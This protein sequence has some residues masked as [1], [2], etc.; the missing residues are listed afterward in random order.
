MGLLQLTNSLTTEI[1]AGVQWNPLPQA[2][3]YEATIPIVYRTKTL[4]RPEDKLTARGSPEFCEKEDSTFCKVLN[5]IDETD[6][7]L[8]NFL[9]H[10]EDNIAQEFRQQPASPRKRSLDFVGEF[11]EWCCGVATQRRL[12]SVALGEAYLQKRLQVLQTGLM[13]SLKNLGDESETFQGYSNNITDCF[14]QVSSRLQRITKAINIEK[15]Q[16]SKK[17]DNLM[18]NLAAGITHTLANMKKTFRLANIIQQLDTLNSCRLHHIPIHVVKP[19]VLKADLQK[20]QE[21]LATHNHRLTIDPS[22]VT[23]YYELPICDCTFTADEITLRIKVPIVRRDRQWKLLETVTT[24]FAWKNATCKLMH[25]VTYLAVD[26]NREI[27]PISG[28]HLH[29][30]KPYETRLCFLP[31]FSSD[32]VNGHGCTYSMYRGDTIEKL[33]QQCTL[34]Y[35]E[36]TSTIITEIGND[37]YVI[38]H[39]KNKTWI[40]CRNLSQPLPEEAYTHPGATRINLPGDCELVVNGEVVIPKR[41]PCEESIKSEVG[42]VHIIPATWSNLKT[43]RM[44]PAIRETSPTFEN[45][46]ECINEDWELQVP[47]LRLATGNNE[48]RLQEIEQGMEKAITRLD[49][50]EMTATHART[51]HAMLLWNIGLTLLAMYLFHQHRHVVATTM[52]PVAQAIPINQSQCTDVMAWS[53]VSIFAIIT[54]SILLIKILKQRT[55]HKKRRAQ[56]TK[57]TK[58]VSTDTVDMEDRTL[59]PQAAP[60]EASTNTAATGHDPHPSPRR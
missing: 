6:Q 44:H 25:D 17:V 40:R 11:A 53:G 36:V 23:A 22:E 12:E 19:S 43:Y 28:T 27:R 2:I 45:F 42:I 24:P 29:Q 3:L 59:L 31:R 4:P 10:L 55:Q 26:G 47:H 37:E 33:S 5:I 56:A 14:D 7:H 54:A 30:C 20:L 60:K 41:F 18:D 16:E 13:E 35:Q 49:T 38:T 1:T 9:N 39:P 57:E 48:K 52:L 8:G 51:S 21:R 58:E 46:T 50:Q 32:T 15:S 34:Q